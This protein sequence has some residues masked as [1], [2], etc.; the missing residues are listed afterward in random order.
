MDRVVVGAAEG[1]RVG[2]VGNL[3][4]V[5]LVRVRLRFRVEG[6]SVDDPGT[7][8]T[9][10]PSGG[11]RWV[12]AGMAIVAAIPTVLLLAYLAFVYG[13]GCGIGGCDDEV[14]SPVVGLLYG[15]G[16]A[17]ASGTA[18]AVWPWAAGGRPIPAFVVGAV[19][20]PLLF[21]LLSLF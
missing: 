8:E 5:Q 17:A 1:V 7:G 18:F 2:S 10:R 4:N 19:A 9:G 21:L 15:L 3:D 6:C 20:A 16:A 11:W 14:A 12:V 13:T